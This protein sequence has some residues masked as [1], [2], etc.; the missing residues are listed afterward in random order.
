MVTFEPGFAGREEFYL[1]VSPGSL[2]PSI[3]SAMKR[4]QVE[5]GCSRGESFGGLGKST[6]GYSRGFV[7]EGAMLKW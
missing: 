5:L 6:W 7:G 4:A 1:E 2:P 3:P